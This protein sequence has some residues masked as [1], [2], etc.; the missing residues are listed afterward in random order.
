MDALILM[1][2][3]KASRNSRRRNKVLPLVLFC[4]ILVIVRCAT[5]PSRG[6]GR[7]E[8]FPHLVRAT[9]Q[10]EFG[11]ISN[12]ETCY[13][14]LSPTPDI[15]QDSKYFVKDG[16]HFN[17]QGSLWLACHVWKNLVNTAEFS[18]NN[19]AFCWNKSIP[20]NCSRLLAFSS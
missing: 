10:N 5:I 13:L 17:Q 8:T 1:K 2:D 18:C 3:Q 4:A 7:D 6:S 9:L 15:P 14:A 19:Y 11:A 16:I 20:E 12:N